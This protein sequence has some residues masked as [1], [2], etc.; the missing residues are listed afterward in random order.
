MGQ[1][2]QGFVVDDTELVSRARGQFGEAANVDVSGGTWHLPIEM[3][4]SAFNCLAPAQ[5]QTLELRV[6][7][8]LRI[9]KCDV[10]RA[11]SGFSTTGEGEPYA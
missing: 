4:P 10:P 7:E 5:S 9:E 11:F 8:L 2:L 3:D 6:Q 1:Q